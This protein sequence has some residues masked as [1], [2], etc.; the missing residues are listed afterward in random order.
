MHSYTCQRNLGL[1]A[2]AIVTLPLSQLIFN[3]YLT[4]VRLNKC[5]YLSN[6]TEAFTQGN[7]AALMLS[8][9]YEMLLVNENIVLWNYTGE[10]SILTWDIIEH[11]KDT[12]YKENMMLNIQIYIIIFN[13][14]QIPFNI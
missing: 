10:I 4:N 8:T 7:V 12:T 13:K 14:G 1:T 5:P 2:N 3:I 9:Y 6:N 11:V